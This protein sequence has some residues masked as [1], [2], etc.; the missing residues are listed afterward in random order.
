ML[1]QWDLP[2]VVDDTRFRARFGLQ[3]VPV[4]QAA[5]DT[6]AWARQHYGGQS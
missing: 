3:P 5:Q 1:Y 6:A 2:F 4:A